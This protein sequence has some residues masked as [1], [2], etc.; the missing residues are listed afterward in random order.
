MLKLA[1]HTIDIYDVDSTLR[2]LGNLPAESVQLYFHYLQTLKNTP[3]NFLCMKDVPNR[4]TIPIFVSLFLFVY[5]SQ[6]NQHLV[7]V[8]QMTKLL[9]LNVSCVS[10]LCINFTKSYPFIN[11]RTF[12]NFLPKG[13]IMFAQKHFS[14]YFNFQ[15]LLSIEK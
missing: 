3:W 4:I 5:L 2:S 9:V 14:I 13:K 6:P 7:F 15:L 12:K 11:S 10:S 8:Q 1:F